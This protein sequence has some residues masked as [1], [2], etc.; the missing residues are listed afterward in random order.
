MAAMHTQRFQVNGVQLEAL[1]AGPASGE[2]VILLHGFPES[3]DAWRRQIAA[4]A[5][6]GHRVIAPHQRGYAG[7]SKPA[8]VFEYRIGVLARDVLALADAAGAP[9]FSLVGHDWGAALAWHLAATHPDRLRHLVVLNGPHP[10]TAGLHAMRHPTQLLRSW[11]IGAFQLPV[12]PELLLRSGGFGALARMLEGSARPGA[13]P[14]GLLDTY[15]AQWAQPGALTAMLNWYRALAF[16]PPTP[17]SR[18]EL[19][20][21]VLWGEQ[22]RWLDRGLADAGLALC[23]RGELVPFPEAT[24]WLHHE[25]PDAVNRRLIDFVAP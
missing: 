20:V 5:G 2:P 6:A 9:Q 15:R 13:F 3:A 4:L 11:Y 21:T 1:T 10:G 14:P 18:I 19:P 12:V 8:S 25:E 16:D 7:S 17:A 24:H 22:D 23:S